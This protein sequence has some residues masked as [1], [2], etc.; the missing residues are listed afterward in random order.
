MSC[1][2]GIPGDLLRFLGACLYGD[3]PAFYC[4]LNESERAE[5]EMKGKRFGLT[6]WFYRYLHEVLPEEKR[7]E[8]RKEYQARQAKAIMGAHELKRLYG[9]LASHGLR[10]VPVKGADLTYRLYPDTA[11]RTFS[12][13]DIWFHPDDCESAFGVLKEDGWTIP[14]LYS[15]EQE[16]ARKTARHHFSPHVRGQY[17]LEPHF[18]LAN[19]EGVDPRE[20]WDGTVECP[21]GDGQRAL[22]PEMNL[23]MLARHAASQSYYHTRL[24]KLLTD[25]AMVMQKETVD[26]AKLRSMAARWHLPYPGDLLAAF[27]EFFP[28]DTIADFGADPRKT[29]GFRRV[30]ELRGKMGEP[31]T[32]ALLLGRFKVRGQVFEGLLNHI[33]MLDPGNIRLIYRLPK[34]GARGRVAWSYVCYF[35]TRS[36]RVLAACLQRDP[37]LREYVSLVE[38]IETDQTE[39]HDDQSIKK[40]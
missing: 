15:D 9:V 38:E 25:A 33:K 3:A 19:F 34:H 22:S 6:A 32:A 17:A 10:F 4:G 16:N 18:T 20:M 13:W 37:D 29:A 24:P 11:L 36:W 2:Y 27:P 40:T 23:L 28:S 7:A 8:Y 26:F 5:L 35:S 39:S 30:F 1:D 31:K 14:E 21:G 12:D